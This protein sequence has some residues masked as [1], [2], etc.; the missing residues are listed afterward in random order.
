MFL[1]D[2]SKILAT[3]DFYSTMSCNFFFLSA[4]IPVAAATMTPIPLLMGL[5][6]LKIREYWI[7]RSGGQYQ[8]PIDQEDVKESESKQKLM[9]NGNGNIG[10]PNGHV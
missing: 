7:N 1:D 5:I 9:L 8:L 3:V 4:V 10:E 2:I 6:V